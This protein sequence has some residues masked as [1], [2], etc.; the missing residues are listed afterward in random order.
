MSFSSCPHHPQ[1]QQHPYDS[2]PS[3]PKSSM[4]MIM[5][6]TTTTTTTTTTTIT[7]PSHVASIP[8]VEWTATARGT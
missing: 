8:L 3:L 7:S 6:P 1:Q 2:P 5:T 4:T